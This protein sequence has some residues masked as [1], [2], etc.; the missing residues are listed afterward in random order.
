MI[1]LIFSILIPASADKNSDDY[2]SQA[3]YAIENWLESIPDK[4][5]KSAASDEVFK[6]KV[7]LEKCSFDNYKKFVL[8]NKMLNEIGNKQFKYQ[9]YIFNNKTLIYYQL[10]KYS[11]Y[12]TDYWDHNEGSEEPVSPTHFL[13]ETYQFYINNVETKEEQ[14]DWINQFITLVSYSYYG[15]EEQYIASL[16]RESYNTVLE[17][18]KQYIVLSKYFF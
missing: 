12:Y 15:A 8:Y 10:D 18:L 11:N 13:K 5:Y 9:R 6:W 4:Q 16:R 3:I 7:E 17:V 2:F 14:W 1:I